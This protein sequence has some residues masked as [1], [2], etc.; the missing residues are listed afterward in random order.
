MGWGKHR[1]ASTPSYTPLHNQFL[2]LRN[3]CIEY[4]LTE[5]EVQAMDS[6]H[7]AK[8]FGNRYPVWYREQLTQARSAKLVAA[9]ALNER[10]L[11]G[12]HG[13]AD[14]LAE[15]RAAEAKKEQK[16]KEDARAG[17]LRTEIA[18]FQPGC[19]APEALPS[20]G[21]LTATSCLSKATSASA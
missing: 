4:G 2:G 7:D 10:A 21:G 3:S 6:D 11:E 9:A 8:S 20:T 19:L 13:G 15:H 12:M 16:A 18:R 1:R 14:G 5:G 17:W